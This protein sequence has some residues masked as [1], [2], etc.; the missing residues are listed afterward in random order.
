MVTFN[1]RIYIKGRQVDAEVTKH[2]VGQSVK[3][4]VMLKD[5]YLMNVFGQYH[6]IFFDGKY[7]TFNGG[8][9]EE[10]FNLQIALIRE[11]SHYEGRMLVT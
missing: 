10:E 8:R 3:Y 4:V 2:T 11:I 7:T 5:T 9:N 6:E 1:I